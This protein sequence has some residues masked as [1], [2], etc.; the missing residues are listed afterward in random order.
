MRHVCRI[1]EAE[2]SQLAS[3]MQLTQADRAAAQEAAQRIQT[4]LEG[5][6]QRLQ[7]QLKELE[8][9]SRSIHALGCKNK[10]KKSL[11]LN[12][13]LKLKQGRIKLSD[14]SCNSLTTVPAHTH[15][16]LRS[17]SCRCVD[18]SL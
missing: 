11:I 6:V 3:G 5:E 15:C 8:R 14:W 13:I 9:S 10:P 1:K 12:L 7:D 18:D 4:K 17:A 2:N 16:L